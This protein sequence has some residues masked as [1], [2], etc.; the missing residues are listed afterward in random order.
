MIRNGWFFGLLGLGL[1][2]FTLLARPS[3]A[4]SGTPGGGVTATQIEGRPA[5]WVLVGN[6][7]YFVEKDGSTVL[8]VTASGVL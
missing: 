6:K 5:A 1:A 3:L 4:Q 8:K 2:G 7:L